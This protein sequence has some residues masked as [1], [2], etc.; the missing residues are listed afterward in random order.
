MKFIKWPKIPRL[1]RDIIITEKIDGTNAHLYAEYNEI[2]DAEFEV[3]P[4]TADMVSERIMFRTDDL[5]LFCGSRNRYL[6]RKTD[7]FGF[8]KWVQENGEELLALGHGRHYGEW[9]GQGIQ[10]NYGLDHKRFSLFNT[11]LWIEGKP[12]CCHVVPV[13]Y[14]GMFEMGAVDRALAALRNLG[15]FAADGFVKPEGVVVFHVAANKAFKV[16]C[17]NDEKP[18]GQ[19]GA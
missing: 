19:V 12:E 14:S 15:S 9:W 11:R 17:E 10:R 8:A 16:T 3:D 6:T 4:E 1:N 7:N 18:K 5:T 2:V 13:L